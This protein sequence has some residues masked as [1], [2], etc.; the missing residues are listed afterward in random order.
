MLNLRRIFISI[1]AF[2]ERYV[3]KKRLH[4][5]DLIRTCI[6]LFIECFKRCEINQYE[7]YT[8]NIASY[9]LTSELQNWVCVCIKYNILMWNRLFVIY[10][11]KVVCTCPF[12][13]IWRAFSN[14]KFW[15][16]FEWH[17]ITMTW[18][19]YLFDLKN[20]IK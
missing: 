11:E 2:F 10:R 14:S 4:V 12:D 20:L 5:S 19:N 7:L 1:S 17:E 8:Q 15:L 6:Q 16:F 9:V 3:A 13:A 18:N